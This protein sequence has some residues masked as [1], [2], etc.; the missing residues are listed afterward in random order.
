MEC[1]NHHQV[2][3]LT[4]GHFGGKGMVCLPP[5]TLSQQADSRHEMGAFTHKEE[6]K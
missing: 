2:D 1:A 4:L 5:A 6:T 3:E